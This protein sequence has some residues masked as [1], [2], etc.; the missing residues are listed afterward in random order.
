MNKNQLMNTLK[1]VY[2]DYSEKP[3]KWFL[4]SGDLCSQVNILFKSVNGTNTMW[5]LSPRWS[6]L[7]C[8]L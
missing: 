5:S 1:A 3:I 8:G 2:K 4:K 7:T 6:L